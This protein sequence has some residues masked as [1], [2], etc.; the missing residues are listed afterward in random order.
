MEDDCK[1][2]THFPCCP[3]RFVLVSLRPEKIEEERSTE[4]KGHENAGE[5][6]VGRGADVVV[7]RDVDSVVRH[8]LYSSL[9]VGVVCKTSHCQL[10]VRLHWIM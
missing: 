9:S 2:A 10:V 1:Y 4:D 7:I 5:D 3:H 8:A 6:V